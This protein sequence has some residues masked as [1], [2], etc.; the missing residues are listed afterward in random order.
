MQMGPWNP[1]PPQLHPDKPSLSCT[2]KTGD[3][4]DNNSEPATQDPSRRV[5]GRPRL[6]GHRSAVWDHTLLARGVP[7]ASLHSFT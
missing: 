3:H 2:V 5:E 6:R 7:V 1:P 4:L